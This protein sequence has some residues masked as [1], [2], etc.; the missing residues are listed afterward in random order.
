[1]FQRS[2]QRSPRWGHG[3]GRRSGSRWQRPE[4]AC[5]VGRSLDMPSAS[6][7][8]KYGPPSV[9]EWSEVALPEPSKGEIRIK[10]IVSG[11]GPTDLKIRRGS[12]AAVYPLPERA[13]LGFETAGVVDAVGD[14]V[15][16]IAVGDEGAAQLMTRG[17]YGEFV[18]ATTWGLKPKSVS[19]EDA[20]ALPAS[21]EAA[22]RVLRALNVSS[23]ETLLLL[24]AGGSVGLIATQLALRQGL[25]VIAA[26]GEHD[27]EPLR[28]LGA[29]P[30]RY[31]SDLLANVRKLADHVDA[32]FDAAGKGGL[33]EAIRLTDD[34]ARVITLADE[35]ARDLG[36]AFSSYT[37][38]GAP[39]AI[40]IGVELLVNGELHLRSQRSLPMSEAAE[41]HRLLEEEGV[42]E[43]LLLATAAFG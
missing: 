13:V 20:G 1:M 5:T 9:L 2:R 29:T 6:V 28:E 42:R 21:V 4:R 3:C 16:G 12:L 14:G 39:D 19:W 36:V 37:P 22:V 27:E 31:G 23:G 41:A 7:L 10:A 32:T 33:E 30:V 18:L 17:G 11:V 25:H 43:K 26:V 24:G 8:T 35:R 34:R 15:T 40:D 38:E